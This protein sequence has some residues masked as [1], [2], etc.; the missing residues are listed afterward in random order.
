MHLFIRPIRA[1][2]ELFL[3]PRIFYLSFY[4]SSSKVGESWVVAAAAKSKDRAKIL[5]KQWLISR[6]PD[7][8]LM[9]T[10]LE[11]SIFEEKNFSRGNICFHPLGCL[12]PEIIAKERKVEEIKEAAARLLEDYNGDAIKEVFHVLDRN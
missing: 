8:A 9:E 12:D 10:I 3:S 6:C 11:A 2:I 5:L 7:P 4:Y 1:L